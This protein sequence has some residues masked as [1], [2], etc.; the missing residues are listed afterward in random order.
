MLYRENGHAVM[1]LGGDS[2][3]FTAGLGAFG[4]AHR[5]CFVWRA[6]SFLKVNTEQDF[7]P[8]YF[9]QYI[10]NVSIIGFT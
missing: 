6:G 8:F 10:Y 9:R 4:E 7:G 1:A 2:L 5:H 3:K